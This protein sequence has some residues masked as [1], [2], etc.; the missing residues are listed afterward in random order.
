MPS[1]ET[2]DE[3]RQRLY[4][5]S[6]P[7]PV[8]TAPPVTPPPV[9]D[10][11]ES[12][13]DR[14]RRLYGDALQFDTEPVAPPPETIPSTSLTSPVPPPQGFLSNLFQ[15]ISTGLRLG[16]PVGNLPG[17]AVAALETESE[18]LFGLTGQN[19]FDLIIRGDPS[20][21]FRRTEQVRQAATLQGVQDVATG[22]ISPRQFQEQLVQQQRGRTGIEQFVGGIASPSNV[23]PVNLGV[24][25]ASRIGRLGR[26]AT[27]VV[28][29][30]AQT[31]ANLGADVII[32]GRRVAQSADASVTARII[33]EAGVTAPPDAISADYDATSKM[34]DSNYLVRCSRPDNPLR[35][36]RRLWVLCRCPSGLHL[37][38]SW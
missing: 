18:L 23:L 12:D 4:G 34:T 27:D 16:G 10:S 5:G 13:D 38:R 20:S 7:T 25:A 17:E 37:P 15:G 3:R 26:P 33:P 36:G 9:I 28:P 24:R 14:R 8:A 1:H 22:G 21:P 30:V 29:E 2:D 11:T 31:A 35:R 6:T 19:P 32:N